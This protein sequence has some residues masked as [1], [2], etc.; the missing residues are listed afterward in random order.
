MTYDR[1]FWVRLY[2]G[3]LILILL[4]AMV[5]HLLLGYGFVDTTGPGPWHGPS[6]PLNGVARGEFGLWTAI[7]MVLIVYYSTYV[8]AW[9]VL[10]VVGLV[11]WKVLCWIGIM[12]LG[13]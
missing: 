7:Q 12:K 10:F 1:G 13:D 9:S 4:L 6:S 5:F 3:G 2:V 11:F 8:V